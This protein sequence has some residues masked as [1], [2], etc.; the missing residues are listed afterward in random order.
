MSDLTRVLSR[1][2]DDASFADAVRERPHVALRGFV[3]DDDDLR[4]IEAVVT[5]T[6]SFDRLLGGAARPDADP[7]RDPAG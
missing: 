1:L 5:G 6:V 3:L 2:A 7:R 4:R